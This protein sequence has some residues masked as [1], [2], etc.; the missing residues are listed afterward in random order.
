MTTRND[1][2]YI[3]QNVFKLK[4]FTLMV[5]FLKLLTIVEDTLII[6]TAFINPNYSKKNTKYLLELCVVASALANPVKQ[7]QKY[8]FFF[9][10]TANSVLLLFIEYKSL[11]LMVGKTE[12]KTITFI[13]LN[14]FY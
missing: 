1:C 11:Y 9:F 5:S 8:K 10:F 6:T 12:V 3:Q 13:H 4:Y 2:N 7:R 14:I